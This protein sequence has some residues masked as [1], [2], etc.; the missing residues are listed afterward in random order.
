MT[1]DAE[2]RTALPAPRRS[3]YWLLG[4]SLLLHIL[5]LLVIARSF[6]DQ[7]QKIIH[8]PSAIQAT[9]VYPTFVTPPLSS[10]KQQPVP[11]K[12]SVAPDVVEISAATVE[13]AVPSV[14]PVI[15]KIPLVDEKPVEFI[16]TTPVFI[17]GKQ[18]IS[19]QEQV[20]H[21][22][23]GF[24]KQALADVA[25]EATARYRRQL[26]SPSLLDKPATSQLSEDEKFA[27]ARQVRVNCLNMASQGVAMLS[28]ITGGTIAC[29]NQPDVDGFIQDRLNNK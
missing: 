12:N 6:K 20:Q 1:P 28:M 16:A 5:L 23:K 8:Q 15:K 21:Q 2:Y 3:N 24:N 29:S 18:E 11:E 7:P 22:L 27:T 4:V 25:A 26:N 19:A 14:L 10:A 9:L 17:R 13:A